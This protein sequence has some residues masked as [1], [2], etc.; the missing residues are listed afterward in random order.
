MTHEGE[1][2][3]S[4]EQALAHS[5]PDQSH[6]A[7]V[8]GSDVSEEAELRPAAA[9]L[10]TPDS[11]GQVEQAQPQ[12]DL[13]TEPESMPESEPEPEA[14]SEPEPEVELEPEPEPEPEPEE[15]KV[16]EI[17]VLTAASS[18]NI[19]EELT[20]EAAVDHKAQ[21]LSGARAEIDRDNIRQK[22]SLSGSLAMF[23]KRDAD[24]RVDMEALVKQGQVKTA[25][26]HQPAALQSK[27]AEYERRDRDAAVD[28]KQVV[29]AGK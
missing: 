16:E 6:D 3:L 19:F 4:P 27:L 5:Q 18:K 17:P 8:S 20:R 25:L 29:L 15:D 1:E 10:A 2:A 12:S 24:A 23:E 11:D 7:H 21:V 9:E 22:S 14:E 28:M 13:H 26:H